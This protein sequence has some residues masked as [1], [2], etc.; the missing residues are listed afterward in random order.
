MG[1]R[2]GKKRGR[3]GGRKKIYPN[4]LEKNSDKH[5]FYK[6]DV[7]KNFFP[8]YNIINIYMYVYMYKN[9]YTLKLRNCLSKDILSERKA[10]NWKR[11]IVYSK[12]NIQ[13]F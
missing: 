1:W 3:E 11:I 10:T 12:I 13:K 7:G 8:Q 5:E 4:L 6:P 2:E 9:S